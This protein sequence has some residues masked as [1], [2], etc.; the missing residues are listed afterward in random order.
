MYTNNVLITRNMSNV[1]FIPKME[2][3]LSFYCKGITRYL[4]LYLRLN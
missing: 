2:I 3:N 1:L 4:K